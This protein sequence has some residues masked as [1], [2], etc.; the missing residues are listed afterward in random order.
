MTASPQY[1]LYSRNTAWALTSQKEP[2]T[3]GRFVAS[4]VMSWGL[5]VVKKLAVN[6]YFMS[7]L[8]GVRDQFKKNQPEPPLLLT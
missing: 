5:E 6:N 8:Y 4:N 7:E 2:L 1:C 3:I